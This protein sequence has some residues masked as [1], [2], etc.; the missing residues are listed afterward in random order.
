MFKEILQAEGKKAADGNVDQLKKWKMPE[1]KILTEIDKLILTF[2][3]MCTELR[4]IKT[5]FKK[6]KLTNLRY[7]TLRLTVQLF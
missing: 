5:L 6:T 3:Q 2:I 1:K 4:I 7:L